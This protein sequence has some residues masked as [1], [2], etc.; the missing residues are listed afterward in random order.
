MV[1][2]FFFFLLQKII[3]KEKNALAK[4]ISR[5]YVVKIDATQIRLFDCN[6]VFFNVLSLICELWSIR[7]QVNIDIQS[8][9][10]LTTWASLFL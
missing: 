4:R 5:L 10:H 9:F 6:A 1:F 8:D 3:E 7:T 2:N